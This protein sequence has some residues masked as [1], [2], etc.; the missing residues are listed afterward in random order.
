MRPAK[1]LL[2]VLGVGF[3]LAAGQQTGAET[4]A[5]AAE[6]Q[7]SVTN[8]FFETDLMQA[9]H[10]ISSQT[11]VPI[12]TDGSVAGTVSVELVNLP[13]EE[14]LARL[15]YPLGY[16]FRRIEDYYL[17][18]NVNPESP[19]FYL[20]AVTEVLRPSYLRADDAHKLLP[21]QYRRYLKVSPE[22]NTLVAAAPRGIID[23]IKQDLARID[24]PKRQVLIEALVTEISTEAARSLGIDW[25]GVLFRG[26][27]TILRSTADLARIAD[28]SLG[29]VLKRVTGRLGDWGY[30]LTPSLQALVRDGKAKIKASPKL[31]TLDGHAAEIVVGKEQYYQLATGG[32]PYYY[33][34]LEKIEVGVS[35]TITPYVA[36]NGDITVMAEPVVSDV[37][38]SSLGQLPIVSKRKAKTRIVV[39]DGEN[40]VIG[41]LTM[42]SEQTIQSRI[43]LLGS[44]PIVG[45][46]FS[47]TRKVV[48]DNEVVIVITPRLL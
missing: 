47:H 26:G 16:A 45:F 36:D 32:E 19:S 48:E 3:A 29:L 39:R 2:V 35:L 17:V 18:G 23:K 41:G 24:K 38:G 43:P 27:D 21:D 13:L 25:S 40:V 20:I 8:V 30:G 5:R 28:T 37:V 22:T 44:I 9:L 11:R 46:L 1:M 42:R 10:D 33:L 15:L 12:V 34:R 31:V 4:K 6:D 14:A 7:P